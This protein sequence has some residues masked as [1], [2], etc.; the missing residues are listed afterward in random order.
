MKKFKQIKLLL[1]LTFFAVTSVVL[2]SCY[3]D[4]GLTT[5]DFDIVSTFKDDANDFQAYKTN[6][7]TFFIPT[8]IDKILGDGE[9]SNNGGQYDQ[10]ILQE[11]ENQMVAYGYKKV[12]NPTPA[13]SGDVI[14]HVVNWT[15]TTVAYYPGYWYGGY[16]GGY[17]PYYGGYSYSY[18]TGTLFISMVDVSKKDEQNKNSGTVWVG[19]V[20]GLMD[21]STSAEIK[22][23]AINSIDQM[24]VQSPYLKIIE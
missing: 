19:A 16:Y 1:I 14:L 5:S 6:D 10:Q 18:T 8:T 15:S 13:D 9:F 12:T 4:Y 2:T 7:A 20:N 21:S 17:Y 11:I 22:T 3:P 23:R 24:F